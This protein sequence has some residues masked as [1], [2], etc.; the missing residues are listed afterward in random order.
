MNYTSIESSAALRS[1]VAGLRDN[2]CR[3]VAVDMEADFNLHAYGERL[4]LV[5]IFD[6]VNTMLVDPFKTGIGAVGT[7]F[8]NGDIL[9]VM[10]DAPGDISLLKN[11]ANIDIR[12]IL[13]LR[14]AVDLLEY[15]RGDL[16]S[17]IALELGVSLEGKRVYQKQNWLVRPLTRRAIDYALND[18]V[19][20]LR[21]K[22][23][24]LEKLHAR[25]LLD[26]FILRNL[27]I[28]SKDYRRNP[29]DRYRVRGYHSLQSHERV[30]FRR[31]F[32]V[33]DRIARRCNL[34]PHNVISRT[35][36]LRIS[37]DVRRIDDIRFPRR[38]GPDLI[39][40]VVSEL[41]KAAESV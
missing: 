41:R 6:G 25:K 29:D 37:R 18:V 30:I 38:F 34:P 3:I 15:S 27:R 17:I 1:Y 7:L 39:E 11:S 36:M 21:L 23:A 24:L 16:H 22:D 10:Y 19:H 35:D 2:G 20:L 40:E 4:C 33:R 31:M 32:D 9:K 28:Q 8:K 13:D 12:S 26:Q 5:Q 14:P